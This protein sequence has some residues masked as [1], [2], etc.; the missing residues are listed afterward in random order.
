[1]KQ[2][3]SRFSIAVHTLSLVAVVPNECTGDYIAK[4]VNTNPVI[5]RRIMSKLKQAGLIEVRPGVGGASLLK[6]PADITLLD[7]YRALEVVEDGELFNFHKHPNPNCPVGSMIEQTLRAELIE[8]Q[9][10]MEQR[11]NRVT[12]QQMMDQVHVSE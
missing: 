4:S 6:D 9:T 10:A 8:A 7:I 2:I 12:I 3:S 11:L 1:M 5:I